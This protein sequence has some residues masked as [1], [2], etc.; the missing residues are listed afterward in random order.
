MS[1]APSLKTKIQPRQSRARDTVDLIIDT[2]GALLDEV[3]LEQMSTNLVCKRA[4]ISPPALYRY[5]PNKHSI[6]KALGDKVME[7]Q[8]QAVYRWIE[9]GGVEGGDLEARIARL[10]EIQTE[11]TEITRRCPGSNAIMR[12]MRAVPILHE[13]RIVSRNRVVQ[14]LAMSLAR[15]YPAIPV[16]RLQLSTKLVVELMYASMEMVIEEPG[17]WDERLIEETCRAFAVYF[18]SLQADGE[19]GRPPPGGPA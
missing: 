12:A 11:V 9:A 6:L 3:G 16:E 14:H 10:V 4:G 5:F 2:A 13:H 7:R 15:T 8:D 19:A 17:P 18:D 1:P